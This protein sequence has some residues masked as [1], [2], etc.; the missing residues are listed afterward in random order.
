MKTAL[1]KSFLDG[2]LVQAALESCRKRMKSI[3]PNCYLCGKR[4]DGKYNRDHVPPKQCFAK[5]LL[6]KHNPNLFW[7][8][9]HESCNKSYQLDE[10]YFVYSLMPFARGSY[11]GDTLRNKIFDDCG[12]IEQQFLL[13]KI[14]N[15]FERRPSGLILPSAIVAKRFE[16]SRILRVA[17][18]I[19]RGL[20][21]HHFGISIPEVSLHGCEL[22]LP[23][24][25]PPPPFFHLPQEPVHG[26]YPAVFDYRFA[27]YPEIHNFNYWAMLLWD[28]IIVIVKFQYPDCD[29]KECAGITCDKA[30][31]LSAG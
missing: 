21:Y 3:S 20:Y 12:H 22:I 17:W 9:T 23:D 27:S 4:H 13:R 18:K 1:P 6:Q 26:Q 5:K 25:P 24:Q 28:R 7:L 31:G 11:S 14:L 2:R 10:D 30:K 29:C 16:G 19:V 8:P 15:E